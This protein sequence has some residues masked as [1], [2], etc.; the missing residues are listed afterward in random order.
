MLDQPRVMLDSSGMSH[1]DEP[2]RRQQTLLRSFRVAWDGLLAALRIDR[3]LRI[4]AAATVIVAVAGVLCRLSVA[5]WSAIVL[6]IGLVWV[7]ELLN[8]SIEAVVDLASP[9]HHELARRAKDVA[10]A[11]VLI[12]AVTAA[13][14]GAVIFG[15]RLKFGQ[16]SPEPVGR[17]ANAFY[18]AMPKAPRRV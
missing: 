6:A 4:H 7:A 9:E 14:V 3:N 10:S 11:A 18:D 1:P 12:A 13:V 5:E 15:P 2:D 8:T 16:A 17:T